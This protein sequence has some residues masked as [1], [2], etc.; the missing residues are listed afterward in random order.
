MVGLGVLGTLFLNDGLDLISG[1][2]SE[3]RGDE[4]RFLDA[5]FS[6]DAFS[7]DIES[8]GHAHAIVINEGAKQE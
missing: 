7:R 5:Y 3:Y 8:L 2:Y 1:L 6:C 4:H